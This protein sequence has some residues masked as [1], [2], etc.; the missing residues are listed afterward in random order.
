[1]SFIYFHI[2][3]EIKVWEPFLFSCVSCTCSGLTINKTTFN[4]WFLNKKA[5][6][7]MLP[8]TEFYETENINEKIEDD[9]D[10]ILF[11]QIHKL[12]CKKYLNS[13]IFFWS[14][15]PKKTFKG[16]RMWFFQSLAEVQCF[17]VHAYMLTCWLPALYTL[18]ERGTVKVHL[19]LHR[20]HAHQCIPKGLLMDLRVTVYTLLSVNLHT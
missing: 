9:V 11:R 19:C 5:N 13:W 17:T 2:L 18:R 6:V 14:V 1:M 12:R 16:Q 15:R 8:L 3:Q 20:Y 4:L 10:Q 7:T